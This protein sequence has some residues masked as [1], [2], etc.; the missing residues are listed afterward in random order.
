MI[1]PALTCAVH[2]CKCPYHIGI[3]SEDSY[4]TQESNYIYFVNTAQNRPC[5][6]LLFLPF[7]TCQTYETT[8]HFNP[9]I[10]YKLWWHTVL[11]STVSFCTHK[12]ISISN[13]QSILIQTAYPNNVILKVSTVRDVGGMLYDQSLQQV[14]SLAKQLKNS[15]GV[16]LHQQVLNDFELCYWFNTKCLSIHIQSYSYGVF[17][18][19]VVA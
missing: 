11:T 1:W 13:S 17:W 2:D 8:C 4:S 14:T 15:T 19:F 12:E 10:L 9:I 6:T 18:G 16:L 5:V 3:T 7:V